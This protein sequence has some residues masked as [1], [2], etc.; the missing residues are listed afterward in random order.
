MSDF[1]LRKADNLVEA[2]GYLDSVKLEEKSFNFTDKDGK[3]ATIEKMQGEIIVE[4]NDITK[5]KFRVDT[6]RYKADGT[7]SKIYDKLL[8]IRDNYVSKAASATLGKPADRV[9]VKGT[10]DHRDHLNADK[11]ELWSYGVYKFNYAERIDELKFK[12]HTRFDVEMYTESIEDEVR[13]EQPTGAV[14]V[15][16]IVPLFN[17]VIP[18]RLRYSTVEDTDGKTIDLG[19]YIK[20]NFEVGK[21][22]RAFGEIRGEVNTS[23][24]KQTIIG[25]QQTFE[26]VSLRTVVTGITPQYLIT[27][28]KHFDKDSI[29]AALGARQEMLD[30]IK[31]KM[32]NDGN[33]PESVIGSATPVTNTQR[34]LNW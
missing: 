18:L 24:P 2:E 5:I 6:N 25:A 27:D 14:F 23:A 32:I 34:E 10:F 15:N 22:F 3:N 31:E 19:A 7:Q 8:A 4:V 11:T 21:T 26:T 1:T 13:D 17:C 16:G 29:K 9:R 33:T 30:K 12:P 28:P 20:E